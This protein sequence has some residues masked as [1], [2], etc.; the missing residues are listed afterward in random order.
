MPLRSKIP[1]RE[2]FA[3]PAAEWLWALFQLRT[4][5]VHFR[6]TFDFSAKKPQL[7]VR[8]NRTRTNGQNI[9]FAARE[10]WNKALK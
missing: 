8:G 3:G 1:G 7:G 2:E 6:R 5:Q 10:L 9:R 4:R